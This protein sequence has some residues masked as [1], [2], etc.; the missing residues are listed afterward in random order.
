MNGPTLPLESMTLRQSA[1]AITEYI[2]ERDA[3]TI[4]RAGVTTVSWEAGKTLSHNISVERIQIPR[5]TAIK[6]S[7]RIE[8][9][10]EEKIIIP[11]EVNPQTP[12]IND[13]YGYYFLDKFWNLYLRHTH[14]MC[15]RGVQLARQA[16]L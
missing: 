10:D 16:E 4:R 12:L 15:I 2:L 8:G 14:T 7:F 3:P 5:E 6:Y 9:E 13:P 1:E 11:K